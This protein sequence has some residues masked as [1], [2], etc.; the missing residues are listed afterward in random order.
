MPPLLSIGIPAYDRPE[1]LDRAV[2][3]T[4]AQTL[5]DLEVIVS[6]DESPN[7]EVARAVERLAAGDPRVRL[8]RQPH[9]LG[10]V[11]NYRWVLQAAQGEFFMWLADDDWLDPSY[12]S[13]CVAKLRSDPRIR[14][15]CGQARYYSNG[16]A[17]AYERPIDLRA[18]RPGTRVIGYYAR[19]NMN[20]PLFGVARRAD[21][22]AMPFPDVVGGDWLLVAGMAARGQ[23]R[24]LKEVH[25]HRSMDGLGADEEGL[26]RS[27]GLA[28]RWARWHH[29]VVAREVWSNIAGD[30][31]GRLPGRLFTAS[32]SALILLARYPGVQLLRAAGLRGLEQRAVA[33][34]RRRREAD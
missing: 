30:G 16:A 3:S 23:V 13:S 7:P 4:L 1:A 5:T 6:D 8:V 31:P 2:R 15:V 19:V 20:G 32:V 11:A 26:A 25:L 10:H 21:W 17:V 12:A 29:I 34:A 28:G 27:F 9:N 22:L 24:T 33:W 14:L 18:T